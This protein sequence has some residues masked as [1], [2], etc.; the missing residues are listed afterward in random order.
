MKTQ[1]PFTQE[2]AWRGTSRLIKLDAGTRFVTLGLHK[3]ST[4]DVETIL[5]H[6]YKY[7]TNVV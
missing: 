5:S 1:A 3:G 2:L 6:L 7:L 4:V